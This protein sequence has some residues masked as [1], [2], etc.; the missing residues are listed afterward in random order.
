VPWKF[1]L[2]WIYFLHS[3]FLSNL[4]LLWKTECV[5][6][7]FTVLNILFTFKIF[8]QLALALKNSVPWNFS[9]YWISFYIQEFWATCA[10]LKK[11]RVSPE[12]FHYIEYTFHIQ[13]FWATCACPEKQS[14]PWKFSLYRIYFLHSGFLSNLRLPWKTECVL[15]FFIVLNILFTFR[16]FEQ[17]A[18]ALKNRVC[19]EIFHCME[20]FFY[21]SGFWATCAC[22]ENRISPEIFQAGGR[23]PSPR[24]PAYAG[25]VFM[26][27]PTFFLGLAM[28]AL[29]FILESPL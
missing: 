17:L 3:G 8:E 29:F 25:E 9:L 26:L 7:F 12:I 15:K 23:L 1:S 20:T 14:V 28:P 5:L 11:N 27:A 10:S 24:P 18:L 21:H 6:K 4:R 19:P 2:Y 13:D 22:P 16:I